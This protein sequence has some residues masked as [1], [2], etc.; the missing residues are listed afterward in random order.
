VDDNQPTNQPTTNQQSIIT[1][2]QQPIIT[3]DTDNPE[4]TSLAYDLLITGFVVTLLNSL[5][6]PFAIRKALRK[7]DLPLVD[8]NP[9][10]AKTT[11]NHTTTLLSQPP[12]EIDPHHEGCSSCFWSVY[13]CF[14]I[15]INNTFLRSIILAVVNDLLL[16]SVTI[17]ILW[18]M[19][20][21]GSDSSSCQM[22]RVS[23]IWFKALW[24]G[25]VLAVVYPVILVAAMIKY[26]PVVAN[27]TTTYTRVT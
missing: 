8:F 1:N 4:K 21:Q 10:P 11:S 5:L 6:M 17:L 20:K 25:F 22:G 7:G 14:P 18:I 23:F 27:E 15:R 16:S 13:F 12:Q 26:V 19:C 9:S 24:A 3:Q 2:Q